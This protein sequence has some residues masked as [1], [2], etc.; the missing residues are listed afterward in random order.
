MYLDSERYTRGEGGSRPATEIGL[1]GLELVYSFIYSRVGNAADAEDLT[2]QV[3]LKAL[4][5]LRD[6]ATDAS[7]RAYLFVTAR[8]VLAAFWAGRYRLP[9]SELGDDLADGGRGEAVEASPEA[10]AWLELTLASLPPHY[11]QVLELRF[12]Q[13]CSLR[14]AASAMGK[15]VGAVKLMQMRALRAAALVMQPAE[16]TVATRSRRPRLQ[17]SGVPGSACGLR[18]LDP[19]A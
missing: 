19:I 18:P 12:L 11:R 8:S 13:A 9:E 17:L 3:A 7:I 2:Q 5:R 10:A 6:G 14:E 1:A 16:A 4:H 15:S